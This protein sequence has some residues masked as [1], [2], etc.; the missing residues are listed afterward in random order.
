MLNYSIMK[1]FFLILTLNLSQCRTENETAQ[2]KEI[3]QVVQTV[4]QEFQ[5]L[6]FVLCFKPLNYN[7]DS[8]VTNSTPLI[9]ALD[10]DLI[11]NF[12]EWTPTGDAVP[13]KVLLNN[14]D[15]D[16]MK[17]QIINRFEWEKE[18]LSVEVKSCENITYNIQLKFSKPM[19]NKEKN[20]SLVFLEKSSI[21]DYS[22]SLILLKKENGNWKRLWSLGM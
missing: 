16:Y 14:E 20:L 4:L 12:Q 15:L 7:E 8:I 18:K 19:L 1:I 11:A 17:S 13:I 9:E 3:Y 22:M 2:S 10:I 6:D 5:G 21:A